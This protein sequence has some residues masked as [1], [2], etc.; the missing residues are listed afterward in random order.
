MPWHEV[1][2]P[3]ELFLEHG[4]EKIYRAYKDGELNRPLTYWFA[5]DP[6][7]EPVDEDEIDGREFDIRLLPEYADR[8]VD[9]ED[10]FQD[11]LRQAIDS[12]SLRKLIANIAAA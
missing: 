4:D 1:Y 9:D 10:C 11:V 5:V 7:S 2:E 8:A 6:D 3:P 12:G